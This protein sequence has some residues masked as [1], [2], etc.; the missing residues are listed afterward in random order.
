MT[1]DEAIK[2]AMDARPEFAVADS[3][4]ALS[5]EKRIVE[6]V[7]PIQPVR[8]QMPKPGRTRDAVAWVVT[9]G[10]EAAEVWVTVHDA[11]GDIVRFHKSRNAALGMSQ[12]EVEA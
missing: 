3:F 10:A 2:L 9:L 12:R 7:E 11:S 5:A 4:R 6:L 8:D 1:A